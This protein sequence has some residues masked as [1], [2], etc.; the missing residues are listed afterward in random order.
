HLA[1][2]RSIPSR[3]LAWHLSR[4]ARR[5]SKEVPVH[6]RRLEISTL[7]AVAA[8]S[9]TQVIRV[10]AAEPGNSYHVQNLVSD[11]SIAADHTD[12]LL[13]NAWGLA[14]SPAGPW[15]VADNETDVS[16]LYNGSGQ[17]QALIVQVAGGPTGTV[18]YGG[19]GF[20]VTNGSQSGSAR[21]MFATEAG[22]I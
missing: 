7:I 1:A 13:I 18:Y 8:L 4:S 12:P 17:P 5:V 22:T 14:A 19:S 15:W 20:S 6:L 9:A 11:G 16:T 10:G 2:S 21:F 3:E